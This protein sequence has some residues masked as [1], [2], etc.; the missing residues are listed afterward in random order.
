MA[1]KSSLNGE[2][3]TQ[4]KA[5]VSSL[6]G[7]ATFFVGGREIEIAGD[8]GQTKTQRAFIELVKRTYPNLKMLRGKQYQESEVAAILTQGQQGLLGEEDTLPEPQQE[9]LSFIRSNHRGGMRTTVKMLLEKFERKTYGWSYAAVLGT[10]AY[11]CA[12]GKVEVRESTNLL[13]DEALARALLNSNNHPSLLLDPQVEFTTGQTKKLKEFYSDYFDKVAHATEAKALAKETQVAFAKQKEELERLSVQVEK[14]PFLRALNDVIA[15]LSELA[16]KPY[17]WFVT[18]L[19]RDEDKWLDDYKDDLID[20]IVRFMKG[21]NKD[22]LDQAR[23]LITEHSADLSYVQASEQQAIESALVDPKIYKGNAIQVLVKN[24]QSLQAKLDE[25]IAQEKEAAIS[26]IS[27]LEDKV[28]QY[29]GYLSL[30]DEQQ[31]KVSEQFEQAGKK[32]E[33]VTQIAV[34][35]DNARNFE[36]QQ[37]SNLL[38]QISDWNEPAPEPTPPAPGPNDDNSGAGNEENGEESGDKVTD[39]NRPPAPP[40][41]PKAEIVGATELTVSFNKPLLE[42]E[43]DI[44]AY[45]DSY[46]QALIDTVKQGKKV[47]V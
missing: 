33:G 11:L 25:A 22:K 14:Y 40:P 12:K 36:D 15:D 26:K 9:M 24:M 3:Y 46:K 2:R 47:R 35:R 39:S 44:T 4:L 16:G 41:K 34:I 8:D 10:L 28:H 31:S 21:G 32:I 1:E 45:I 29:D 43:D 23:Q 27:A 30:N 18:E 42:N 20:P 19:V 5:L 6:M 17:Q 13:E 37:Y 7:K 38:Q